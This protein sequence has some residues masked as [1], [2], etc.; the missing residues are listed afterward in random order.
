MSLYDTEMKPSF[1]NGMDTNIYYVIMGMA[2][3]ISR[4]SLTELLEKINEL[5][6]RPC[7]E[8]HLRAG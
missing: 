6:I 2:S 8:R 5:H 7:L 3:E 1:S 4:E